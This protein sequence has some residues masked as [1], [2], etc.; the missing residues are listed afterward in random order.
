MSWRFEAVL[1]R[2]GRWSSPTGS[3]ARRDA[4]E[5]RT[6]RPSCRSSILICWPRPVARKGNA[7]L[8]Q[9]PGSPKCAPQA[10]A[11]GS[12][13]ASVPSP[14]YHRLSLT[15]VSAKRAQQRGVFMTCLV[16]VTRPAN[17]TSPA[18]SHG[19]TGRT[20]D[21]PLAHSRR[22]AAGMGC[23]TRRAVHMDALRDSSASP[24]IV[25]FPPPRCP[26]DRRRAGI[27]RHG[28]CPR[29]P[30]LATVR[31]TRGLVDQR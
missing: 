6:V 24:R 30:W 23:K 9:G 31:P 11:A 7:R 10:S 29:A 21:R 1:V 13:S 3:R 19:A 20:K 4:A 5:P 26:V 28:A 18:S 27:G 25:R 15:S 12:K 17:S 14:T 2:P 8:P 22:V 16:W